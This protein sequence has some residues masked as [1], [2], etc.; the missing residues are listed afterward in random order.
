MSLNEEKDLG[1]EECKL[2]YK[3]EYDDNDDKKE[4]E[5]EE[6]ECYKISDSKFAPDPVLPLDMPPLS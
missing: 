5:D 3:S 1:K 6:E 4:D 2:E